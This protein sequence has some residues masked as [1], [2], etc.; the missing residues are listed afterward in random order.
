MSAEVAYSPP[1][2]QQVTEQPKHFATM[3]IG[4]I[5]IVFGAILI[6]QGM[7][8]VQTSGAL[9]MGVGLLA[10]GALLVFAGAS[11]IW[12]AKPAVDVGMIIGGI[13][14]LVLSGA[15][16]VANWGTAMYGIGLTILGIV[17]I[18]VGVQIARQGWKRYIKK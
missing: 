5:L 16:L 3:L 11:R 12:P 14:L 17:M 2:P 18:V 7:N 4:I 8:V 6:N 10:A 13:V 1:V 9:M 15:E